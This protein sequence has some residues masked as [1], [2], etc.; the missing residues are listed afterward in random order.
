M[1]ALL[2]SPLLSSA[3]QYHTD[4]TAYLHHLWG[5]LPSKELVKAVYPALSAWANPEEVLVGGLGLSKVSLRESFLAAP[6]AATAG[7]G[8]G[9]TEGGDGSLPDGVT[10]EAVATASGEVTAAAALGKAVP[11]AGGVAGGSFSS[12]KSVRFL[13]A[14]AIVAP[15]EVGVISRKAAVYFLDAYILLLVYYRADAGVDVVMPPPQQSTLWRLVNKIRK[16]RGWRHG[17]GEVK[18]VPA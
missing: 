13:D 6:A 5:C 18:G 10:G 11:A 17:R 8:G 7:G 9:G 14:D 15:G 3:A 4:L 12:G 1:Y 16:V 2:R